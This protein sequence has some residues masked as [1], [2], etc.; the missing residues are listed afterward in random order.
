MK[1]IT[2]CP[3]PSLI[4]QSFE[5][6]SKTVHCRQSIFNIEQLINTLHINNIDITKAEREQLLRAEVTPPPQDACNS[7]NLHYDTKKLI[8]GEYKFND[9]KTD[10]TYII[11][12]DKTNTLTRILNNKHSEKTTNFSIPTAT[13]HDMQIE[14]LTADDYKA[15]L[16]F[17]LSCKTQHCDFVGGFGGNYPLAEYLSSDGASCRILRAGEYVGHINVWKDTEGNIMLGTLAVR[18]DDVKSNVLHQTMEV[19]AKCLLEENADTNAILLGM[20]GQNLQILYPGTFSAGGEGYSPLGKI[21]HED[22]ILDKFRDETQKISSITHME[23]YGQ[24]SFHDQDSI[25]M[26][27]NSRLDMKN[28]LIFMDAEKAKIV[29]SNASSLLENIHTQGAYREHKTNRTITWQNI[30]NRGEDYR[31][32]K[33]RSIELHLLQQGI[34]DVRLEHSQGQDLMIS[35]PQRPENMPYPVLDSKVIEDRFFTKL[36]VG[37]QTPRQH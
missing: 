33:F 20:G 11:D 23:V 25:G 13:F 24:V 28:A 31:R 37:G 8:R 4:N 29:D 27:P 19:F 2:L 12:H 26:P 36:R 9:L 17:L 30:Q 14:P 7:E 1:P 3:P 32:E 15:G 18:Q 34:T 16:P 22:N 5:P 6:L 35:T 21:R 10:T